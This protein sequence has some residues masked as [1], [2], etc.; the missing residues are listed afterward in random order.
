MNPLAAQPRLPRHPERICWGCPKF[1][2]AN[3]MACGNEISR[4]VHPVEIFGD[5]WKEFEQKFNK[6]KESAL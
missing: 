3:D 4:A 2:P 1:C 5:D 6:T